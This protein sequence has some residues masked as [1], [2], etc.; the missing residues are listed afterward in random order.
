V[1]EETY[2]W[3]TRAL[4]AERRLSVAAGG[5]LRLAAP[6]WDGKASGSEAREMADYA[7]EIL[8]SLTETMH[9]E[10]EVCALCGLRIETVERHFTEQGE[11]IHVVC[12]LTRSLVG[13]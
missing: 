8:V 5:L 1:S 2:K 3:R 11:P 13:R 4:I 9:S 10:E 6:D 12:E 7:R